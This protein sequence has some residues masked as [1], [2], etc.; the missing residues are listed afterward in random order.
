MKIARIDF[1]SYKAFGPRSDTEAAQT[2]RLAPL[3]FLFGKNN[4][5]KSAVARLPILMLGAL[6]CKDSRVLPLEVRGQIYGHSFLDIAFG[7][8]FFSRPRFRVSASHGEEVLDLDITLFSQGAL[9]SDDPPRFWSYDMGSPESLSFRVSERDGGGGNDLPSNF[10]P[11]S[12]RWDS[13]RLG[14]SE[15][16]DG[17][18]HLGPIRAHISMSYANEA[19]AGFQVDGGHTPQLLRTSNVLADKVGAWY[20]E[21]LD[22]WR[23]SMQR[24]SASFSLRI[25]GSGKS[26]TNLA[27][28]GEGLQQVLP[29]VAHQLWRQGNGNADFLDVIEQPELHLHPAAQ[30]PLADLFIETAIKVGGQTIVETNSKGILL[31]LQ[32]RI[33]EG[34]IPPDLVAL[35]FVEPSDGG[36]KL[37]EIAI[38]EDGELDWWPAGVFEEDFEEVAAI[39]RAQRSADVGRQSR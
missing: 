8:D 37:R 23:L 34:A 33:A 11:R 7:G 31:R 17:M 29:V 13:L 26:S 25:T 21:H 27:Q 3:T 1:E 10:L 4:S 18:I 22:G 14:A 24:D 30:A 35:Y 19:F 39:R 16:L 32:R 28:S 36:S 12:S 9:S 6:E 2:L 15:L 20:E 5:G 38:H